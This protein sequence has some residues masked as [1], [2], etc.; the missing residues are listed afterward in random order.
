MLAGGALLAASLAAL[1]VAQ[2]SFFRAVGPGLAVAVLV[3]LGASIT[4]VP[5]AM[6]AFGRAL[7]WPSLTP[8]G[9]EPRRGPPAG[10]ARR[11]LQARR[12]AGPRRGA[13][14]LA[15]LGVAA[16]QAAAHAA[17]LHVGARAAR[18]RPGAAGGRR[19]RPGVRSGHARADRDPGRGRRRCDAR[20][21][22]AAPGSDPPPAG[23]RRR[24]RPGR[25]TRDLRRARVPPGR[26]RPLRGGVRLRPARRRRN[27]PSAPPARPAARAGAVGGARRRARLGRG[28]HRAG[29]RDD[30]G[31]ATPTSSGWRWSCSRELPA[32]GRLPAGAGGAGPAGAVERPQRCGRHGD[33]GVGVPGPGSATARS[34]TTCRSRRRCS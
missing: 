7:F 9:P 22:G 20:G 13:A 18:R 5:A 3:A 26:R 1:Q 6:A 34:R 14:C 27:R 16:W 10:A 25:A 15:G 21:P 32:A 29:R 12:L 19:R 31:D 24:R 8:G 33:H 28:R 30:L 2:L 17:R 23:R 11:Q 4:L